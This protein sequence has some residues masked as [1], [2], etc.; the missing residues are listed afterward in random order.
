MPTSFIPPPVTPLP[1]LYVRVQLFSKIAVVT[2]Y[3]YKTNNVGLYILIN[4]IV[5][6][7]I[8]SLFSVSELQYSNI[9]IITIRAL[10]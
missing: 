5:N 8:L 1:G 9:N 7:I 3:I 4:M 6:Y 10:M 2:Y